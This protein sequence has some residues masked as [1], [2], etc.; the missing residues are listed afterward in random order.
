MSYA[1]RPMGD[2]KTYGYAGDP[3]FLSSLWKGIKKVALP[4]L[5]GV[6]GGPVGMAV[7]A[8]GGG[9]PAKPT[10]QFPALPG[11]VGGQIS[12]PGGT[13]VGLGYA[14][15]AIVPGRGRLPPYTAAGPGVLPG[16]G[17]GGQMIPSGYHFAKDGSGRLVRNRRMNVANP[18]ALR[19]AMRRVQGF[20]KLARRTIV[21]TRRVKMKKRKS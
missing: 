18:R 9:Y 21:F 4:I 10:P 1:S 12:F 8:A 19:K 6:I 2:Y 14:P 11:T 13:S 15:G 16:G 3:G 20:E 17:R 7:G 5:G